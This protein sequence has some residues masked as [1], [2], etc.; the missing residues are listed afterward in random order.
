MKAT[1][2]RLCALLL[3]S[4][5]FIH[6]LFAQQYGGPD[7]T[8]VLILRNGDALTGELKGLQRGLVT[9]KTDAASTIYVKWPRVLTATTSKQFEIHL[10]DGRKY[11]GS[12]QAGDTTKTVI[13]RGE[14]D[15][16]TV[17]TQSIVQLT[18]LGRSF[19]SR[20]SGSVSL[21]FSFTQQSSKVDLSTGLTIAYVVAL[22]RFE[23]RTA[24]SFSRQDSASTINSQ[25]IALTWNREYPHRWLWNVTGQ[26]QKNSQLSLDLA[27]AV[28]TGPGR[29]LVS[30]NRVWLATTLGPF[31]RSE[32]YANEDPRIAVPLSLATD[33]ELFSWGSLSTD[34]SSRLSVAPVLNDWGRWQ[35]SFGTQFSRDLI[36]NL[37]LNLDVTEYFDS[38][39]PADTN[40]NAFS[41]STSLAW[42]FGSG[43]Y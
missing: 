4:S 43:L 36:S 3:T 35:I 1:V 7:E 21:G 12:L 18:R 23:L 10:D 41:V 33:F 13:I 22:H 14:R 9:Y 20:F 25:D 27:I 39:P 29:I 31:F 8:D 15:T 30:T 17:P 19:W 16:L 5:S 34:L 2:W 40:R 37:T 42:T 11:F 26:V 32:E 24:G 28:G 38:R 6:P